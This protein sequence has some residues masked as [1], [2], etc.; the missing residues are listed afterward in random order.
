MKRRF[1]PCSDRAKDP[2]DAR[3][4]RR[5]VIGLSLAALLISGC[6]TTPTS[7]PVPDATAATQTAPTPTS[8]PTPEAPAVPTVGATLT[9]EQ[10]A[11]LPEGMKAYEMTDGTLIAVD[12]AQPLPESVHADI[13]ALAQADSMR[14]SGDSAMES[15]FAA[16]HTKIASKA[17]G[18]EIV[19]ILPL[20]GVIGDN[21]W[22][23]NRPVWAAIVNGKAIN[24]TTT[25]YDRDETIA[26]VN[27]WVAAQP[28]PAIYEV[29]ILDSPW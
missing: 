12:P 14:G 26:A 2:H 1:P 13:K 9:A 5:P 27:A 10:A 6:A 21:D 29:I 15:G 19:Q 8:D 22:G 20:M 18:K 11:A 7:A 28:N 3:A 25:N 23:P 17:T 24:K 16:K 4:S